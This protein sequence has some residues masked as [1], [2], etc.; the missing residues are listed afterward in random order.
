MNKIYTSNVYVDIKL[1]LIALIFI[2]I[3]TLLSYKEFDLGLIVFFILIGILIFYGRERISRIEF[4]NKTVLI[5][6]VILFWKVIRVIP[7]ENVLISIEK[8]FKKPRLVIHDK[9]KNCFFFINAGEF[10]WTEQLI[11]D[12]TSE[13]NRVNS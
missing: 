8:K 3:L 13:Y 11:D 2:I 1:Y 7:I 9:M 4:K 6:K 10:G 12:I 5:V